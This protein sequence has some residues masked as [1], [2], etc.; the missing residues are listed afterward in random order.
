[1]S[2]PYVLPVDIHGIDT[3]PCPTFQLT[4]PDVHQQHQQSDYRVKM[5]MNQM[6]RMGAPGGLE[7]AAQEDK[8]CRLQPGGRTVASPM[9]K[10]R[11][12][13]FFLRQPN[14]NYISM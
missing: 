13:L 4:A 10:T 7:H 2:N 3:D 5:Q 9:L 8:L 12:M 14:T 1:M 11:Q 6:P